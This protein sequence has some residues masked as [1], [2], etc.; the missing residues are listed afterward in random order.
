MVNGS[1]WVN[2]LVVDKSHNHS[3]EATI[4][5]SWW[6]Q[7]CK[8]L[9]KLWGN[10]SCWEKSLMVR[11]HWAP[12]VKLFTN[13]IQCCLERSPRSRVWT[14]TTSKWHPAWL[15][16]YGRSRINPLGHANKQPAGFLTQPTTPPLPR[17]LTKIYVLRKECSW[18]CKR[19]SQRASAASSCW[20]TTCRPK[21]KWNIMMKIVTAVYQFHCLQLTINK[22]VSYLFCLLSLLLNLNQY[23]LSTDCRI[24]KG[25]S[26][27]W[28]QP[29][30]SDQHSPQLAVK[31]LPGMNHLP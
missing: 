20:L 21:S 18:Q 26:P 7:S 3:W 17:L 16:L 24:R 19:R 25:E 23:Q 5:C 14:V 2:K 11:G 22:L 4:I 1:W 29:S 28:K 27:F 31:S 30:E 13:H 8:Q 12:P 9:P 6:R 15:N 10:T